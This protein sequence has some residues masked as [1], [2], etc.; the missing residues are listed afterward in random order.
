MRLG[1]PSKTE[2]ISIRIGALSPPLWK[3]LGLKKSL[4]VRQQKDADAIV[5]LKIHRLL[6]EREADKASRRLVKDIV[7]VYEEAM[8]TRTQA[9]SRTS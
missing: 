2:N 1:S 4:L 5:R 9:R 3:Q 7:K 8:R 6:P